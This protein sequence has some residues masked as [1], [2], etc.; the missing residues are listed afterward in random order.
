M[1]TF[2]IPWIKKNISNRDIHCVDKG[3]IPFVDVSTW[4]FHTKRARLDWTQNTFDDIHCSVFR[5]YFFLPVIVQ[6]NYFPFHWGKSIFR[7]N[8]ECSINFEWMKNV[9]TIQRYENHRQ[10]RW[11]FSMASTFNTESKY[12]YWDYDRHKGSC[13]NQFARVQWADIVGFRMNF[14][15]F[16][17][18][19]YL[20]KLNRNHLVILVSKIISKYFLYNCNLKKNL[21]FIFHSNCSKYLHL[22]RLSFSSELSFSNWRDIVSPRLNFRFFSLIFFHKCLEE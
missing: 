6:R 5:L 8:D 15:F 14:A 11:T 9:I 16:L 20:E 10:I 17:K 12:F 18:R 7:S 13:W 22:L 1:L 21:G 2:G 19:K 4:L 3:G